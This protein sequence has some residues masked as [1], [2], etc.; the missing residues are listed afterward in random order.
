MQAELSR[1]ALTGDAG[2]SRIGGRKSG[3]FGIAGDCPLFGLGQVLREPVLAL[4]QGLGMRHDHFD[5]VQRVE[6]AQQVVTHQQ[7]HFTYHMHGRAQEQVQRPRHRAF[8]GVLHAHHTKL[9]G[10]GGGGV[11]HLVEVGAVD[12]VGGATEKLDRRLFAE[13][14]LRP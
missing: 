14:S 3:A 12:Q 6:L 2:P 5:A 7:A 9:C 11:E 8:G 4:G 10:A 1:S 13:R